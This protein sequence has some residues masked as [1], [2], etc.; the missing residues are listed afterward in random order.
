MST[1]SRGDRRGLSALHR[2]PRARYKKKKQSNN[3]SHVALS[4]ETVRIL[5]QHTHA[6]S[7]VLLWLAV[8]RT[9]LVMH[10]AMLVPARVSMLVA[11]LVDVAGLLRPF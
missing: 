7:P 1:D 4:R 9:T 6:L 5:R 2:G 8:V 11:M 10:V 3:L